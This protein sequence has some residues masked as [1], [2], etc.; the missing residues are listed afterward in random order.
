LFLVVTFSGAKMSIQKNFE[1]K[2]MIVTPMEEKSRFDCKRLVENVD[3][4]VC[5]DYSIGEIADKIGEAVVNASLINGQSDM[6][7]DENQQLVISLTSQ[8]CNC[9]NLRETCP[10]NQDLVNDVIEEVV[11]AKSRFENEYYQRFKESRKLNLMGEIAALSHRILK[12]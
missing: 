5:E 10:P 1:L 4:C 12:R 11:V 8:V 9:I 3:E 6:F 7:E 2:R